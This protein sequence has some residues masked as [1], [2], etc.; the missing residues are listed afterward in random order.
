MSAAF[1]VYPRYGVGQQLLPGKAHET[2]NK[3]SIDQ[4]VN[5]QFSEP[6]AESTNRFMY[7][8]KSRSTSPSDCRSILPISR[9]A[10]LAI[11]TLFS[12]AVPALADPA[13]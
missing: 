12:I 13:Q 1:F 6:L 5:A 4:G 8:C 11:V 9:A 2:V 3:T 7:R 10:V